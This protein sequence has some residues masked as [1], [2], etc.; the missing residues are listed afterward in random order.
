MN[1]RGF[2][3]AGSASYLGLSLDNVLR[4][5]AY[6]GPPAT[7]KNIINIFL[8]GGMATQESWDPKPEAPIEYRGPY[9]SISTNLDGVRIGELFPKMA[10]IMDKTVLIR[11]LTHGEAAHERGTHNMFTGYKPSAAIKYPSIGSIVSHELGNKNNLPAYVCAPNQP[12]EFAGTGY[13]NSSFGPF[14]L[15]SDPADPNFKVRDLNLP[16]GIDSKRFDRRR[17]ILELVDSPFS[18]HVKSSQIDAVDEFYDQAYNIIASPEAQAAFDIKLEDQKTRE[19]YGLNQAGQRMLMARRLV[20]AGVRFATITYG[21]WD[22]HDNIK[23]GYQNN[24]PFLDQG[25]HALISDLDERGLLDTTMVIV[26]S[27]FGRTPKI[28]VTGGR[29]H[30]PKVY[31]MLAAGGG[32]KRGYVHGSSTMTSDEPDEK[33]TTPGD[34]ASTILNQLGIN[35]DRRLMTPDLRPVRLAPDSRIIS[36]ILA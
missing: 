10:T 18:K 21:G 20:E 13:L 17:S 34:L 35:P 29:D 16:E 24:A 6:D 4:A 32:L 33:P 22:M 30:W 9:N 14:S 11:S 5:G 2:L 19:R 1:R 15:G 23:A 25:L 12:N 28:N 31:S 8:P 3:V 36:E 26:T 27:E 7:A